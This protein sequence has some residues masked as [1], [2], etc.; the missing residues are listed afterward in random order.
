MKDYMDWCRKPG[1]S[2]NV[3]GVLPQGMRLPLMRSTPRPLMM[4]PGISRLSAS[5]QAAQPPMVASLFAS[6]SSHFVLLSLTI[7]SAR[8]SWWARHLYNKENRIHSKI[9]T[10]WVV[11]SQYIL[12]KLNCKTFTWLLATLKKRW[13]LFPILCWTKSRRNWTRKKVFF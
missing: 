2:V 8:S 1:P 3:P 12:R 9:D 13:N 5:P 10:F 11:I 4:G 7:N 6:I